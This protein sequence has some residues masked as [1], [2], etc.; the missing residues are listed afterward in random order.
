MTRQ[1]TATVYEKYYAALSFERAGLFKALADRYGGTTVLYPGSSVHITP[2]FFFPHVVYVDTSATS[3]AF[4]ADRA[5]VLAFIATR[6]HYQ[7]SAYI[8]YIAQDYTQPLPLREGSFDLLLSLYA[9]N[10]ARSCARYLK[11]GGL[12]LSNDHYGDAREALA[13]PQ[14]ALIA[15]IRRR[16][17]AYRFEMEDLEGYLVPR[18]PGR[19]RGGQDAPRDRY[20]RRADA[21]LFRRIG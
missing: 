17:R 9:A 16:G 19:R 20:R 4:F 2:S 18:P 1:A 10:V 11:P 5:A 15:A 7:R 13:D 14:L 21:Y 8:A 6:K 3:G 12:L